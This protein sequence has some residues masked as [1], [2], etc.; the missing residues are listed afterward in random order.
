MLDDLNIWSPPTTPVIVRID[1]LRDLCDP[2]ECMPWMVE[3]YH[4]QPITLAEVMAAPRNP[5][6]YH[7]GREW[8][9]QE[10]LGRIRFFVEYGEGWDEP[11]CL[12]FD[13]TH[14]ENWLVYDG[15][16]RYAAA[17][18]RD[19]FSILCDIGGFLDY[20]YTMLGMTVPESTLAWT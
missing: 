7:G 12:E 13:E 20:A 18:L 1:V 15:N 19:D 5:T 6:Y 10:H 11:I 8:G 14:P 17:I 3:A 9:L 16:H 2:V 4:P